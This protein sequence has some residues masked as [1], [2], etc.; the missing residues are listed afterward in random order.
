[1]GLGKI[2]QVQWISKAIYSISGSKGSAI[3]HRGNCMIWTSR[4]ITTCGCH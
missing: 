2:H 4:H 1:M 3:G